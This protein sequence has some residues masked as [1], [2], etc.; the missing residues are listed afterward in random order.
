CSTEAFLKVCRSFAPDA[1]ALG[2]KPLSEDS[3]LL[4]EPGL[5]RITD[6][7]M[8]RDNFPIMTVQDQL[9]HP[10]ARPDEN[11]PTKV[12]AKLRRM[13]KEVGAK[14]AEYQAKWKSKKALDDVVGKD[15]PKTAKQQIVF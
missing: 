4:D 12:V 6:E 9:N 3:P 15:F 10:M 14:T 1:T 5:S 8:P 13:S 2:T 11:T 7:E